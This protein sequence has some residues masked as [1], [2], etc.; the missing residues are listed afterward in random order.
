MGSA[1]IS[2]FYVGQREMD[3]SQP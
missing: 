2:S 1:C 3:M